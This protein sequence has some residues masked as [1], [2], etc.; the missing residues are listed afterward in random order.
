GV[1]AFA[2]VLA[3]S[4]PLALAEV[5]AP[6]L[7]RRKLLPRF[8][9]PKVFWRHG[10]SCHWNGDSRVLCRVYSR[11]ASDWEIRFLTGVARVTF[12]KDDSGPSGS[13]ACALARS[14][15]P[16]KVPKGP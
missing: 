12:D 10:G 5:G 15:R 14:E 7:P 16:A 9:E 8:F 4:A 1:A 11:Q 13:P 2:V 6:L 3:H